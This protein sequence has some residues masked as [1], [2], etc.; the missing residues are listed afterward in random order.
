MTADESY[1]QLI[2][3]IQSDSDGGSSS[4]TLT[5][6]QIADRSAY[7]TRSEKTIGWVKSVETLGTQAESLTSRATEIEQSMKASSVIRKFT[8]CNG[9]MS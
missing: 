1:K 3:C 9:V 6:I 8:A 5:Q 4:H 7:T 2:P